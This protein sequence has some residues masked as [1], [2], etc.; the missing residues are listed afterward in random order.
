MS[1]VCHL[2]MVQVLLVQAF[3]LLNNLTLSHVQ[4]VCVVDTLLAESYDGSN[5][6]L[7]TTLVCH[8]SKLLSHSMNEFLLPL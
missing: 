4:A 1:K 8:G 2:V 6:A 5:S 3:A 7:S